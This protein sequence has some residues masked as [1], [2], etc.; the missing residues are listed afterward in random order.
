MPRPPRFVIPGLPQHVIVRGNNR[1]CIF[2]AE[3]DYSTYLHSLRSA[4]VK[5][6]CAIHAYVLMTNHVHILVTPSTE[7][8]L[9]KMVQMV[10]RYYVPYFNQ[11]YRRTGTLWEGRY[12]ASLVDS[13]QYLLTCQRYIEMNPVRA[14]MV[15]HPAEYP[16]SS[17]L[18]NAGGKLSDLVTQHESYLDL[19][20]T[21]AER[22]FTYRALFNS[23]LSDETLA[24]IR[25][26]ANKGWALGSPWFL[27]RIEAMLAR[28]V[29]RQGR[30]G[31]RKSADYRKAERI[32][33][34]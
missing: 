20:A 4:A 23:G 34:N 1:A 31:D 33:R 30:G 11:K 5:H 19:G 21:A 27:Q 17:Y 8:G 14:N 9:G 25:D 26:A 18:V 3:D 2:V 16:W 10:G 12:K 24:E 22:Q 32:N 13:E 15:E 28:P 29:R 6:G 7:H